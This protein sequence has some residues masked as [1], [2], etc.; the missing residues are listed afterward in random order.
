MADVICD[1]VAYRLSV[2]TVYTD[3]LNERSC[4]KLLIVSL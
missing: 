3:S 1:K 2:Y 4:S